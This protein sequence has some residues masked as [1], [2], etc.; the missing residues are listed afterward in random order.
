MIDNRAQRFE[1]LKRE[2]R[3]R[4]TFMTG[5]LFTE[6]IKYGLVDS[7]V[8]VTGLEC[9]NGTSNPKDHVEY[10]ESLMYV[11]NYMETTKC[12]LFVSH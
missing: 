7:N 4:N 9:F 2:V 10:Y 3:D 6:I 12:H 1:D 8:K 11:L 5:S